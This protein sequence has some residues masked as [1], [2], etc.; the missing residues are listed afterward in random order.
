M[1]NPRD[2]GALSPEASG[3]LTVKERDTH[4]HPNKTPLRSSL[5]LGWLPGQPVCQGPG[6]SPTLC[7]LCV[8]GSTTGERSLYVALER[9]RGGLGEQE[10][11]L[12][13][14]ISSFYPAPR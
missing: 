7:Y 6:P 11:A 5:W 14:V 3:C 1:T 8:P 4:T 12:H 13:A 9:G 2:E 10:R